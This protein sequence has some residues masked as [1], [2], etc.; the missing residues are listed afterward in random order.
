MIAST[1]KDSFSVGSCWFVGAIV[2]RGGDQNDR[3]ID[4]GIWE[5]DVLATV[6]TDRVIQLSRYD[7]KDPPCLVS[8]PNDG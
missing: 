7:E 3:F 2:N 4:D 8:P 1:R 6:N 5:H